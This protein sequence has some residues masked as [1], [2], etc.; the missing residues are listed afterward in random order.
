MG[1]V[2]QKRGSKYQLRVKHAL[3]PKA[4]FATF[5]D[6]ASARSYGQGLENMLDRG[7]VLHTQQVGFVMIFPHST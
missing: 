5:A 6:E 1:V 3:L 4:F 2:V 7:V